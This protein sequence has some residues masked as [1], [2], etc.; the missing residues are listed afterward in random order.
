MAKKKNSFLSFIQKTTNFAT[1]GE[2]LEKEIKKAQ[3]LEKR[4]DSA[5]DC[6]ATTV[7]DLYKLRKRSYRKILELRDYVYELPNHPSVL[8]KGCESAV[9]LYTNIK[10]AEDW[11]L[12]N[13][14]NISADGGSSKAAVGGAIGTVAGGLTA[15]LG[16]SAAMAIATTFGTASTGAAISTLG[17][18]AA[19]N[20][21]LAWL[22]GGALAAGGAGVAG[23]ATILALFGPIGVGVGAISAIGAS[24]S[25]RKRNDKQI[26][27][28]KSISAELQSQAYTIN[29]YITRVNAIIEITDTLSKELSIKK[30]KKATQDYSA[31]DFPQKD[32]FDSVDT[33]KRLGRLSQET[34]DGKCFS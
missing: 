32:L 22:G 24:L 8:E 16:P 33:A 13:Q 25:I 30:F 7:N 2:D 23:G 12:L 15:T 10:E 31:E 17:G 4:R 1:H 27:T 11:E 29:D 5:A 28:I 20:A 6:L 19:T 3:N 18:A 34:I 14:Q 21:A 26:E 9:Q